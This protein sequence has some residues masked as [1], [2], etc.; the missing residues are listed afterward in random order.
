MELVSTNEI[1]PFDPTPKLKSSPLPILF[2]SFNDGDN[3]CISCG[4]EYTKTL[5]F[6]QKYCKNC[7]LHYI[8]DITDINKY[9]VVK[10]TG[11]LIQ[12][13]TDILCFGQIC[14]EY[15]YFS[16]YF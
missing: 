11:K 15:F 16:A 7:L 2:V 5:P 10:Y 8:N 1:N 13:D 9:L 6:E 4:D 3:N 12:H 14:S